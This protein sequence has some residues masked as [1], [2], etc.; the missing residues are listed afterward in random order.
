MGNTQTASPSKVLRWTGAHIKE[1]D[2][3]GSLTSKAL[4]HFTGFEKGYDDY[5]ATDHL[6]LYVDVRNPNEYGVWCIGKLWKISKSLVQKVRIV[7]SGRVV[8]IDSNSDIAPLYTHTLQKTDLFVGQHLDALAHP[9]GATKDH[10]W[11]EA[12][13]REIRY[14]LWTRLPKRILIHYVG[15]SDAWDEWIKPTHQYIARVGVYSDTSRFHNGDSVRV[16]ETARWSGYIWSLQ[17]QLVTTCDK[18]TAQAIVRTPP[19][20]VWEYSSWCERQTSKQDQQKE[21]SMGLNT[22]RIVLRD[23]TEYVIPAIPSTR[24]LNT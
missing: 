16:F 20:T 7:H 14:S 11:Y 19:Q 6:D 3:T 4:V 13:I 21:Y 1:L 12:E 9:H 5:I 17:G 2:L 22:S 10:L 24:L 18:T 15:K 8:D 23:A